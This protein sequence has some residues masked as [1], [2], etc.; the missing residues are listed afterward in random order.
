ML[1]F[2]VSERA[3]L[4]PFFTVGRDA[5]RNIERCLLET[6][7]PLET[8]RSILDFG[9]GCGRITLWM[10]RHMA[11][12]A[13]LHGTDTDA[14][15]IAW[16]RD[17][18]PGRFA[19]NA[20]LPPLEYSDSTFDLIYAVSVF[21]HLDEERQVQWLDELRRVLKPGGTLLFSVHGEQVWKRVV[22]RRDHVAILHEHGF[23]F[24]RSAKM[25]GI[26]PD[27]YH[28]SYHTREYVMTRIGALFEATTYIP[29]GMGVQDAVIVRK[30]Q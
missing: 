8:F 30:Q 1:R 24:N 27:W 21:T 28:T 6:G 12:G 22:R 3:A 13:E 7:V 4:E 20:P 16:C 25:S 18:V 23:L 15:A 2:R 9:C 11:A 29:G 17:H 5:C 10:A 19:T 14:E 26:C